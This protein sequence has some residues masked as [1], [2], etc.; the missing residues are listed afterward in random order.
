MN[1]AIFHEILNAKNG[2]YSVQAQ[3]LAKMH[4]E[5]W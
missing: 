4:P 2:D 1:E 3:L 5:G